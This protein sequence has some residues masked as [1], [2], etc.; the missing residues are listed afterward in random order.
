MNQIDF[1]PGLLQKET[2]TLCRENG[3]LVEAWGPLGQGH[4]LEHPVIAQI[5]QV[6]GKSTAQVLLRWC[7][8]CDILPLVKSVRQERI[9]ENLAI[10]DFELSP[11]EMDTITRLPDAR[12][13]T[14]PDKAT[15]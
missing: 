1:H 5:A 8:Q 11:Q 13:G 15:F 10:F 6:H 2:V 7:L 12:F 9:R 3:I 4:L 14:H